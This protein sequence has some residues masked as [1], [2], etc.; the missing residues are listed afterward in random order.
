MD[1]FSALTPTP[2]IERINGAVV[3][4][5]TNNGD[6]ENLGRVKLKFPWLAG[7]VESDW[8]RVAGPGVGK[9]RGLAAV[10]DVDDEVLVVF[11]H[12]LFGRPYVLGGLWNG[13]D[14]PPQLPDKK[15]ASVRLIRTTTGHE[16][17]LDDTEGKERI[18]ITAAD[19]KSTVVVDKKGTITIKAQGDLVIESQS[20]AVKI[21]GQKVEITAKTDIELKADVAVKQSGKVAEVKADVALTL[22]GGVVR[23]N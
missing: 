16:I 9:G 1:L 13:K 21:S 11:E 22:K 7:D 19:A 6:P 20:G 2:Q 12:G 3:A 23:I 17:R 18:E 4:V 14:K 8:A 15:A 5:V 10:P